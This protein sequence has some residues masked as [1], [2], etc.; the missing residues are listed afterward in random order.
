MQVRVLQGAFPKCF[1]NSR[2]REAL[3]EP[4]PCAAPYDSRLGQFLIS[5]T[6]CHNQNRQ[7][8]LHGLRL[9]HVLGADG[10]VVLLGRLDLTVPGQLLT[11]G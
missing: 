10:E 8:S 4:P 3:L 7:Y 9:G 6:G 5:R 2:L 11:I 1:I